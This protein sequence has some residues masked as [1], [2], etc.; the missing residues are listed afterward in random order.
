MASEFPKLR[1]DLEYHRGEVDGQVVYNIKDPITKS[2]FRVREPEYWLIRQLDG[3]TDFETIAAE[4]QKKYDVN[5]PAEQVA[6]FA[7]A[8]EKLYFLE[9]SRAE[10][11]TSRSS[12]LG[13]DGDS[14]FSRL[15][16]I[17]IKA[18]NPERLLD[19]LVKLY[20]P[21]HTRFW[22]V[23][24]ALF[25]AFGIG[26]LFANIETFS[27][28]LFEVFNLGSVVT[29]VLGLFVI[30]SLH[31]FAHA[32]VCRYYGGQV[33]EIGFLLLFFQPCFYSDLSD[34]WLFPRKSQRLAVTFA[35]PY[36]Q[37]LLLAIAVVLWRITVPGQPFNEL[38]R[39]IAIV[40]WV[41][42]LFNFL[43]LIKLDGY[44]LL[45]DWLDIANLR[46][47]SFDYLSNL[48]KRR[49]LGWPIEPMELPRR[50]RRI[51]LA[52][53]IVAGVY[54]VLLL[55][56]LLVLASRFL[57]AKA[58]VLGLL[59]LLVA[60]LLSMQSYL[61]AMAKGTVQH[62][63]YM[64]ALLNKPVR[65]TAYA[66]IVVILLIVLLAIPFDHRVSGEVVVRPVARFSLLFNDFGLLES[67]F[68]LGGTEPR[69]TSTYLQMTSTD[70]ARLEVVPMVRDGQTVAEGDTLAVVIS[71]QVS[72]EIRA[73]QSE[74]HRLEQQLA[75][76]K[77]PPKK[78]AVDRAQAEVNAAQ[79]R[80]DR[81]AREWERVRQMYD[82]ELSTQEELESAKSDYEVAVAE[83]ENR[84]SELHLLNAP[85]KPEEE[86]V[87]R[88]GIETQQAQLDFL[89]SQLD[90]QVITSP[91]T[92]VVSIQSGDGELLHVMNRQT[93][94]L[95]VPISDFDINF[96]EVGQPVTIKVRSFPG[97]TFEGRVVHVPQGATGS[98][99]SSDFIV[100]VA[101]DN[102]DRLLREGMTGYAKIRVGEASL[103]GLLSRK[104]TS[105]LR[106]EFW[107]LW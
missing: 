14:L 45:S 31:E 86:A 65:L 88:A 103:A 64:K 61:V 81:L 82:K 67:K 20:R 39:I 38:V 93:V 49:V 104:V 36:M 96:V 95:K 72:S 15:L 27:V 40:C 75:L 73:A 48:F 83:L 102:A 22:F 68:E 23:L 44:Y 43:P 7:Q 3:T 30:V 56:Y 57:L 52:Y 92:G 66:V 8:L 5:L 12:Y 33:Q 6:Q 28:N 77:S 76:L 25:I 19:F 85:P 51:L 101:V 97:A 107:S 29:I 80:H 4:F 37:F 35:G 105:N 63:R 69:N 94:E 70:M 13:G 42:I 2:Y 26:L 54:T 74:L 60:L 71:N 46:S 62:I 106:V 1:Q 17:K 87:L 100:T 10:Q 99:T 59:V 32:V 58:G 16:L 55:G 18:F 50:Q 84:L 34:A 41:T 90:A 89:T 91:I 24:S 79:A 9:G 78:E 53:A 21:F 47:K 11:A 98:S